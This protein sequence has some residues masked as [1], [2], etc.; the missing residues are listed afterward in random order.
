MLSAS[1]DP[2]SRDSVGDDDEIQDS[3]PILFSPQVSQCLSRFL[4]WLLREE[5]T[6]VGERVSRRLT[7]NSFVPGALL[8]SGSQIRSSM[9]E[10]LAAPWRGWEVVIIPDSSEV[11]EITNSPSSNLMELG[12]PSSVAPVPDSSTTSEALEVPKSPDPNL[13]EF[14][15]PSSVHLADGL[16]IQ[17]AAQ[18][19]KNG[20]NFDCLVSREL[21]QNPCLKSIPNHGKLYEFVAM[22]YHTSSSDIVSCNSYSTESSYDSSMSS[23]SFD[24]QKELQEMREEHGEEMST[25]FIRLT[26]QGTFLVHI[27]F[28]VQ[29]VDVCTYFTLSALLEMQTV[30]ISR[31]FCVHIYIP[32]TTLNVLRILRCAKGIA[33][34]L[35]MYLREVLR[36]SNMVEMQALFYCSVLFFPAGF[37][38]FWLELR[39][40]AAGEAEDDAG[41]IR[42]SWGEHRATIGETLPGIV[43]AR[44]LGGRPAVGPA[45]SRA[46]GG[47]MEARER[48]VM[49]LYYSILIA[50]VW[51]GCQCSKESLSGGRDQIQL[52]SDCPDYSCALIGELWCAHGS[53]TMSSL[54]DLSDP[55]WQRFGRQQSGNGGVCRDGGAETI[56]ICGGG[57]VWVEGE[58]ETAVAAA[59]AQSPKN[60]ANFDCLISRELNQNSCLK[61]IPNHGKLYEFVAMKYDTSRSDIVSCNSCSTESSCDSSMSSESFDVQRELQEMRVE[62]GEE[63]STVGDI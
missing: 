22:K 59:A 14:G 55:V 27:G 48:R 8:L 5:A 33:G 61:S 60:G 20:A 46:F 36:C 9:A 12:N 13:M 24:V 53:L 11:S 54:L 25:I 47:W 50:I 31:T 6:T 57:S 19:P 52:D 39:F 43:A 56:G 29:V 34:N 41:T 40:P 32:V 4:L 37:R 1:P 45:G 42:R 30:D 62:H 63:L 58:W 23:E 10:I 3:S 51:M 38:L 44:Q 17:A 26:S 28:C 2:H 21:N 18:S 16:I 7:G 49:R 35:V 15:N